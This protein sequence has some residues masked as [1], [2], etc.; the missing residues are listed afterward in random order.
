MDRL[1]DLKKCDI[2]SGIE[3]DIESDIESGIE[4]GVLVSRNNHEINVVKILHLHKLTPSLRSSL[5][6][7]KFTLQWGSCPLQWFEI[8]SCSFFLPLQRIQKLKSSF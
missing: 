5:S 3:S 6:S 1:T 8:I 4:S 2:E 7:A